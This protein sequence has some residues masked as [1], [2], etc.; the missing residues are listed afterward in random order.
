[1]EADLHSQL[2]DLQTQLRDQEMELSVGQEEI[3]CLYTELDLR[4][5]SESRKDRRLGNYIEKVSGGM[6]GV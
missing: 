5:E 2:S 6:G 3:K 1:M 4:K